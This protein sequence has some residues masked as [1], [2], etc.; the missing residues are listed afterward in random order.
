[1]QAGGTAWD[2]VRSELLSWQIKDF[3]RRKFSDTIFGA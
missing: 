3:Q 2:S 1:V